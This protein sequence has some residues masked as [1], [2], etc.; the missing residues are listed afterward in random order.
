MYILYF[1][2]TTPTTYDEA[3]ELFKT[4]PC[5][6][7]D[8]E[9]VISFS[10]A[11]LSTFCGTTDK[12]LNDITSENMEAIEEMTLDFDEVKA[13][14]KELKD[15]EFTKN[16][17]SYLQMMLYLESGFNMFKTRIKSKIQKLLPKIRG[18]KEDN[19]DPQK[20]LTDL[21]SDYETSPFR[22]NLFFT[23]LKTRKKEIETVELV[24]YNKDLKDLKH[25]YI[26]FDDD[27]NMATCIM[28]HPFAIEYE[29]QILPED[30]QNMVNRWK[31]CH[32]NSS[33]KPSTEAPTTDTPTDDEEE[34]PT[35]DTPTDDEE[36]C[37]F[38]ESEKWFM[39]T[40][41]VGA[42]QPLIQAFKSFAKSSEELGSKLCFLISLRKLKSTTTVTNT[43]SKT[44][45]NIMSRSKSTTNT[46]TNQTFESSTKPSTE[47]PTT[48]TPTDTTTDSPTEPPTVLSTEPPATE[49]P[50]IDPTEPPP[51]ELTANPH[52]QLQLKKH[53]QVIIP[54]FK[55]P[56]KLNKWKTVTRAWD[57]LTIQVDH[58][59]L[60]LKQYFNYSL[61]TEIEAVVEAFESSVVNID[62]ELPY[63]SY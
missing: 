53:G 15:Y 42:N 13:Y 54:H 17:L 20:E 27:A 9:R 29:L 7:Q 58:T 40:A 36:E 45:A 51:T 35:T 26:N 32:T 18:P 61:I 22:K 44:H 46:V 59:K 48:E 60:N 50:P 31:K 47:A 4:L 14:F 37:P 62:V 19:E 33:T 8:D 63:I 11:P 10:I 55:P 25:V 28:N 24:I 6:A 2:D 16:F 34:A 43:T 49:P 3:V 5:K 39:N 21:V 38:D 52:F 30:P 56:E 41:D 1:I 23:L 57:S 12:I